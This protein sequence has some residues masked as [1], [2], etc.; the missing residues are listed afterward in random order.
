MSIK[1]HS[2]ELNRMLK[3]AVKCVDAN[4]LAGKGNIEISHADN[5]LTIH[6]TNG[7]F[8]AVVS[9]PVPGGDGESFCVDG[10]MF[11]K[12]CAQCAGEISISTDGKVCTVNG[13]GRT[14]LPVVCGTVPVQDTVDGKT[15]EMSGAD[16]ARCYEKV[17]YAVATEEGAR[18]VLTGVRVE[19]ED[20]SGQV[21]M[22]A[23]DGFQLAM[24]HAP[25]VVGKGSFREVIPGKFM[26]LVKDSVGQDDWLTIRCNGTR[27]DAETDGMRV[28]CAVLNND[29]PDYER[30]T[31]KSFAI[32]TLVN[33]GELR[34]ALKSGSVINAGSKMVKLMVRKDTV[35]VSSNSEKAD[36]EAEVECDTQ[37]NDLLIA[38]NQNYLSNAIGAVDAE[39]IVMQFNSAVS[40]CVV[41]E[42]DGDGAHLVLP[43]RVM[44]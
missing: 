9:A 3:T 24:E 11:A 1:I 17:A 20:G 13:A 16:F 10:S 28:S 35:T 8:S 15:I 39:E 12:V 27:V 36:Y 18:V 30:I 41:S 2:T 21:R 4:D 34:A 26:K 38:F 6:A 31:P 22:V 40:P 25:C 32:K 43:V 37:G 5:L 29:Y 19:A 42:R 44:G 33:A 14:R 7:T 23:L